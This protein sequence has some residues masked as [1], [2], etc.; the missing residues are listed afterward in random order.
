MHTIWLMMWEMCSPPV[1]GMDMYFMCLNAVAALEFL[2]EWYCKVGTFTTYA[3]F[4]A[5]SFLIQYVNAGAWL[6]LTAYSPKKKVTVCTG[7]LGKNVR[8]TLSVF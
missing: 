3:L 5:E 8:L 4:L 7:W 2:L 6:T 1:A